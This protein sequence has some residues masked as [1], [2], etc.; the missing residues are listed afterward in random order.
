M[1]R[2]RFLSLVLLIMIVTALAACLPQAAGQPTSTPE[3][4]RTMLRIKNVGD[5]PIKNLSVIFPEQTIAFGDVAA[6]ETTEYLL[7]EKGVYNY[8]A[9]SY[10]VNGEVVTQP[11]IDWMGETPKIGGDFT[12]EIRYT[13]DNPA[14]Q[15]IELVQVISEE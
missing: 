12:Y 3:P 13:P 2:F 6:G 5:Q 15:A 10:E 11:V 1:F 7:A 14:V 9:Y 8:G 4:V